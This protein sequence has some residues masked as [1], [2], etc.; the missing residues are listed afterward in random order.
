MKKRMSDEEFAEKPFNWANA[1]R[2]TPEEH[3]RFK[4]AVENTRKLR[5]RPPKPTEE[6]FQRVNIRLDP[7]VVAWA[8]REAQRKHIGYQTVLNQALLRLASV[9]S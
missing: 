1:R 6:K 9:R 7:R 2:V 5:G 4:E 3:A 8:K